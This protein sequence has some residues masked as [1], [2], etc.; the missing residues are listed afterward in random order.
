MN[1]FE[2]RLSLPHPSPPNIVGS[3]K[4]EFSFKP[5]LAVEMKPRQHE[6]ENGC[7]DNLWQKRSIEELII[8]LDVLNLGDLMKSG[9]RHEEP[10]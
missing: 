2:G 9:K 4:E 7:E 3:I 10:E 5:N 1:K 8:G 6:I